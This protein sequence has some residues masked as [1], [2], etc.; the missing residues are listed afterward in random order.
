MAAASQI[1]W[2]D[3]TWNPVKQGNSHRPG[4]DSLLDGVE[5]RAF[6]GGE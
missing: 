1:S 3:T 6:P 2:T 4:G 5:Y